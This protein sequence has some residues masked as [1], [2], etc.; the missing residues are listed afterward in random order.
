VTAHYTYYMMVEGPVQGELILAGLPW[1]Y[2]GVRSCNCPVEKD[3]YM[4]SSEYVR[5]AM[6]LGVPFSKVVI[7]L[8]PTR[9]EANRHEIELLK[10]FR[11]DSIWG[12]LFNRVVPG[13]F[14]KI[15]Y[16]NRIKRAIAAAR[17]PNPSRPVPQVFR[18]H[19]SGGPAVGYVQ[20]AEHVQNVSRSL[21]DH[22]KDMKAFCA[23]IGESSPGKGGKNVDRQA[24]NA[25]RIAKAASSGTTSGALAFGN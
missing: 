12:F 17:T 18:G 7:N 21:T 2:I 19:R 9:Q 10:G 25:W 23:H 3:R 11:E 22:W 5:A 14:G 4:G 24:F 6:D 20:S 16:R 13:E 1:M 15:D 8:H